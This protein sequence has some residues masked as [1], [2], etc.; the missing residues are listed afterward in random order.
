ME[1]CD[2][3]EQKE[4]RFSSPPREVPFETPLFLFNE[5]LKRA[6][7]AEHPL[8]EEGGKGKS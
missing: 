6:R 8:A 3:N 2:T 5:L 4:K 7:G 1:E